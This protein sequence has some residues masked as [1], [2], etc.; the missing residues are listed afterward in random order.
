LSPV[1]GPQ[2]RSARPP[3]HPEVSSAEN[4]NPHDADFG[5][6][7]TPEHFVGDRRILYGAGFS[8]MPVATE[9]FAI[10]TVTGMTWA[11]TALARR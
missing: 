11:G 4:A 9:P 3:A 5:G 2:A 6:D 1:G 10:V 8:T 7:D